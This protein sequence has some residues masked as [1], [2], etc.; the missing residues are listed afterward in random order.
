MKKKKKHSKSNQLNHNSIA[1]QE[2]APNS[3]DDFNVTRVLDRLDQKDHERSIDP[4]NKQLFDQFDPRKAELRAAEASFLSQTI[5]VWNYDELCLYYPILVYSDFNKDI[6]ILY[7]PLLYFS[8]FETKNSP[9]D[10][11]V[12]LDMQVPI[13]MQIQSLVSL[14]QLWCS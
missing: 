12:C 3:P 13:S 2:A 4:R 1:V 5:F 8:V 7:H 10:G 6:H 11:F 14:V 9:K